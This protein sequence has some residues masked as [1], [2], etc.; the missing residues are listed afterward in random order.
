L[1]TLTS[2]IKSTD[3]V[4]A[5]DH[6]HQPTNEQK[7]REA[8]YW[9]W[10]DLENKISGFSTIGIVPNEKRRE[11]VFLL[12][13]DD[14]R[15]GNREF[16]YREPELEQLKNDINLMLQEKKLAYKCIKPLQ[17]WQILYIGRKVK[18]E[19]TF[20]TRFYLYDFGRD[21]SASWH[22]H[23]E[24]SG[25]ITGE[26]TFK[27]GTTKRI[28]GFG[29]RD[30]SWGY[31]DWFEFEKWYATHFQFKDWN[32]G[33]RKDYRKNRI[34]L[35][36][37]VSDKDGT[38]PLTEFEIE[39]VNDTDKFNSPL[40][41]TYYMKDKGGNEYRIKAERIKKNSFVRFARQFPGGYTELFE[42]MVIMTNLDTGE[43][44][45]GMMEHLRT[46]R[47]D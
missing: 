29:Q 4:E 20:D 37:S 46:S 33:M 13:W 8:Y 32:C 12:F 41:S 1:I 45:T 39:T 5:D 14:G 40:T 11:F 25:K 6:L 16:Y 9:N 28:N 30:K 26:I 47:E 43:I 3:Y 15:D 27:D 2:K 17:T 36:G 42:Q 7:W 24:A 31:R 35:S 23:F 18:L 44:G 22:R 34:D 10:A 19:L 38:L 21:S